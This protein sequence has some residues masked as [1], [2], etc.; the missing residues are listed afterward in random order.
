MPR[1]VRRA[2]VTELV[3][4]QRIS[5]WLN[6]TYSKVSIIYFYDSRLP[7]RSSFWN[8][9]F[10]RLIDAYPKANLSNEIVAGRAD[11]HQ[12]SFG[13]EE[14]TFAIYY[15]RAVG[16]GGGRTD[17]KTIIP[18]SE[19]N[20]AGRFHSSL[21]NLGYFAGYTVPD[22]TSTDP[23]TTIVPEATPTDPPAAANTCVCPPNEGERKSTLRFFIL[24]YIC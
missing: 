8:D 3:S 1:L 18:L 4:A 10:N 7:M 2:I 23:A 9:T 20:V 14:P 15:G 16:R 24:V 22:P 13:I 5:E 19:P 12:V 21:D 17:R 11:I 6:F